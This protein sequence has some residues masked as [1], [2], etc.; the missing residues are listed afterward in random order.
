MDSHY[1]LVVLDSYLHIYRTFMNQILVP[2]RHWFTAYTWARGFSL[3]RSLERGH[4]W[5]PRKCLTSSGEADESRNQPLSLVL[6]HYFMLFLLN[7]K[8]VQNRS[9]FY[10]FCV[11]SWY[12]SLFFFIFVTA[13]PLENLA[14]MCNF[15]L[16]VQCMSLI[17]YFQSGWM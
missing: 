10:L 14:E 5:T 2:D 3:S 7:P 1:L 11:T 16:L 12:K 8:R 9:S 13:T 17:K 15:L 4:P 6:N